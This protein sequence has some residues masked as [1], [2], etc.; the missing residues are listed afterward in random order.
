MILGEG[1]QHLYRNQSTTQLSTRKVKQTTSQPARYSKT[2]PEAE[3]AES[4][5]LS[6]DYA[7][8]V[9]ESGHFDRWVHD[10]LGAP[11]RAFGLCN[12]GTT[13]FLQGGESVADIFGYT[14]KQI[15][16]LPEQWLSLIYPEEREKYESSQQSSYSDPGHGI[17]S[18]TVRFLR[19]DGAWEWVR[20]VRKT[21]IGNGNPLDAVLF[22][23][24][25][26]ESQVPDPLREADAMFRKLVEQAGDG[27]L[28][29]D[30]AGNVLEA[31]AFACE[32]L[33]RPLSDVVGH[34]VLEF[35]PTEFHP[36]VIQSLQRI[37]AETRVS[38][39]MCHQ[40]TDGTIVPVEITVGA[41][42]D[43]RALAISRDITHRKQAEIERLAKENF[44]RGLFENNNSGVL[45]IDRRGVLTDA[46]PALAQMLQSERSELIGQ[47]FDKIF[48]HEH[49]TKAAQLIQDLISGKDKFPDL[50]L[51]LQCRDGQRIQTYGS[52]TAFFSATGEFTHGL[53]LFNDV[54]ELKRLE[55]QVIKVAEQEQIRIGHDLHDGVGQL[56][57]GIGSMMEA[58]EYDL[59]AE[60]QLKLRRIRDLVGQAL[61]D[62]RRISHGLSPAAVK[63]R[64]LPG[65]LQ[66]IADM[67]S[68]SRHC[69][70]SCEIDD[71][72]VIQ[73][74]T[75][76]TQLFRIAQEAVSNAQRHGKASQ[77]QL[78]LSR[79]NANMAALT[80]EDNGT[81][82]SNRKKFRPSDGI[83]LRVMKYRAE[84]IGGE[85][86]I[87]TLPQSGVRITCRFP[88]DRLNGRNLTKRSK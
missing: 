54:T 4:C 17:S 24:I 25:T 40:A 79:I 77:I 84:L 27:I 12:A 46:N 21:V 55:N 82:L 14:P 13:I 5:S 72:V 26:P 51:V 58:L 57:T 63:N 2:G 68:Q 75:I 41:L 62:T 6:T 11:R 56:L 71:S 33:K 47:N 36:N 45:I 85:F 86:L 34:N 69:T 38:V 9:S 32:S 20:V 10:T 83:G 67:V 3:L 39:E 88:C 66:L 19:A 22:W 23:V 37:G 52:P 15:S 76:V 70:A 44:Y 73:D 53:I 16:T 35:V 50:H 48:A 8:L 7:R 65:G 29:V 30:A 80:I 42:S 81:G 78:T 28:L 18:I 31:N 61:T 64:G 43:G 74:E 60:Q 1:I 59:T 87:Q 49:R